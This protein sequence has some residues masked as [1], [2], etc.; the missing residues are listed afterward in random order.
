MLFSDLISPIFFA[1]K[2]LRSKCNNEKYMTYM[3]CHMHPEKLR[4]APIMCQKLLNS[5]TFTLAV[6]HEGVKKVQGDAG[7]P[8]YH[9]ALRS[10]KHNYK[11]KLCYTPL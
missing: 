7:F 1:K 11:Q 4:V 10:F 5:M 2:I 8:A 6:G 9:I 3:A